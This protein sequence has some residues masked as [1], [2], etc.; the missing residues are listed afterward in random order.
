MS[1]ST[2]KVSGMTC[3]NC[4]RHVTEALKPLVGVDSVEVDL[5][6]GRVIVHGTAASPALIA[7]LDDA[8]YP[9]EGVTDTATTATRNG[10][11]CN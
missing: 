5:A 10:C 3:G 11:C 6:A 9:A 7:A 4:V 8:G 1:T 2:F